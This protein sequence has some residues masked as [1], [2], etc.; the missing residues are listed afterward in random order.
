[1]GGGIIDPN[2][3]VGNLYSEIATLIGRGA[4]NI[5]VP[6]LSNLGDLPVTRNTVNSSSLDTLTQFHNADL[7]SSLNS[8]SQQYPGVKLSLLDVNSLFNKVV[9]DNSNNVG[10]KNVTDGCLLVGCTNPDEYLFWDTIHPTTAGH[11][12]IGELA[13]QTLVPAVPE[14]T[15]IL[16]SL[17]AFGSI[18]ALKRKITSSKLKAKKLVEI[19]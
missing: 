11:R 18:V 2:I 7:A 3:P 14:P 6:N 1:L 13:F 16:G 15:N 17:V 9:A 10:F 19:A 5:L 8:L 4:K 12:L